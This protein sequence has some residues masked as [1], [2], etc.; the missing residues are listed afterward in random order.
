MTEGQINPT[1]TIPF[2]RYKELL[3]YE[4]ELNALHNGGVDNWEWYEEALADAG[5]SE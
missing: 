2:D 3:Q 5:L 1:V 4:K